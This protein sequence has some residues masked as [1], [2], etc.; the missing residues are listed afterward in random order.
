LRDYSASGIGLVG[1]QAVEPGTRF[2]VRLVWPDGH[3]SAIAFEVVYC[4]PAGHNT[5]HIGAT[6]P[7][8]LPASPTAAPPSAAPD[9][10]PPPRREHF[11]TSVKGQT[12][13]GWDRILDIR[14]QEDRLW[15][16]M[17]PPDRT[18]GWGMF[19]DRD[20]LEAAIRG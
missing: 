20:E 13:S 2:A 4:R 7:A 18:S 19:V 8:G 6:L 10:Q 5:F 3:R 14:A 12:V 17:H 11:E 15:I 16:N 9:N 1:S